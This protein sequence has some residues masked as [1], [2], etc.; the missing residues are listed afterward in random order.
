MKRALL[1][2]ASLAV[3]CSSGTPTVP[4]V[5]AGGPQPDLDAGPGVFIALDS[6]FADYP[7]W[8]HVVL[9][10]QGDGLGV[11]TVYYNRAPGHGLTAWPVGTMLVK[12]ASSTE[13]TWGYRADV[14][15]KRG[16]DYNHG[17]GG[18][19]DW[20]WMELRP[21]YDTDGGGPTVI[22]WRGITPPAGKGY[23]KITG[24]SCNGCHSLAKKT[25][26]VQTKELSLD[27]F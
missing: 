18:A 20:E 23:G 2:M 6:D 26:W 7:S 27:H 12:V 15:V 8:A 10:D 9:P 17:D 13:T 22:D 16:G 4:P 1:L 25:D 11:R 19:L 14:M 21:L 24:G 3:G 5:D